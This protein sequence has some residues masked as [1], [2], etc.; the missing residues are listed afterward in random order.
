MLTFISTATLK[1]TGVL[2]QCYDCLGIRT[3]RL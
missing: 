1:C 2:A 3:D